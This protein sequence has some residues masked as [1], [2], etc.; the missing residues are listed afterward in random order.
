MRIGIGI[1]QTAIGRP[2]SLDKLVADTK[3]A[4]AEG[5]ATAWFVNIF[6]LD[7]MT[8]AALCGP[9]TTRIELGT[10]VV[11]V[12][13]RHPLFMAQQALTTQAATNGR[14]VLG[15][16]LA[17]Q[18][19]VE[20]MLGLSRDRPLAYMQEYLHVIQPLIGGGAV[21]FVGDRFRVK[22]ALAFDNRTTCPIMLAALGPRMLELAGRETSGT[23]TWAAGLIALR[24]YVV[25]RINEAATNLGR[26]AP[27]IVAGLAIAVVSD[28]SEGRAAADRVFARYLRAPA[29]RAMLDRQRAS[30]FGEVAVVGDA[31]G[32][33][34]QLQRFA[35]V[36]V[37]DLWAVPFPVDAE[38]PDVMERTREVLAQLVHV[39]LAV[40]SC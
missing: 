12:Y 25:P 31:D 11:P 15:L 26:P 3:Q 23:I 9:V 34:E 38:G 24:D 8:V 30:G 2:D 37:T 1:G 13:S 17:H 35:E 33:A 19:I 4:D 18:A 32:V 6:G 27:R 21:E 10:S 22:G 40:D 36:G 28:A 29:Y 7:A 39:K 20:G 16:G 14:F 5:F